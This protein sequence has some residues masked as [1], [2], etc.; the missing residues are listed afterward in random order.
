[1]VDLAKVDEIIDRHGARQENLVAIL[2]DCQ[3][4]FSHL[5]EPLIRQVSRRVEVSVTS[6]LGIA[7]F[8]RA[9]SLEP[10]GK[11][12]ISICMGTA[13]HVKNAPALAEAFER[14]LNIKK[15]ETTKD[16]VF[17][18]DTVNCLGCCGLAPV[19]NIGKDV[20][21]KLKQADIK[22]ILDKYRTKEGENV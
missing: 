3:E 8:F 11:H 21:G 20:H 7:T 16:K 6:V 19:V 9:F 10:V 18:I 12:H 15:G 1:M 22:R 5:P 4:E 17:S 2:L 13:C 14:E